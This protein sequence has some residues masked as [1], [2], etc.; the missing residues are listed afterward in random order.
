ML[1]FRWGPFVLR[2]RKNLSSNKVWLVKRMIRALVNHL[3]RVFLIYCH[4][5]SSPTYKSTGT[6]AFLSI[7][8]G[9]LSS[10]RLNRSRQMKVSTFHNVQSTD[11]IPLIY[12]HDVLRNLFPLL[13]R[14]CGG[15][16]CINLSS[17]TLVSN[18][19]KSTITRL[20]SN[21]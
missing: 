19:H 9:K 14:L 21:H 3:D 18:Y 4:C 2:D 15:L 16:Y 1:S 17:D 7:K 12:E 10:Q 13:R 6:K 5:Q 11:T 8:L 20:Q